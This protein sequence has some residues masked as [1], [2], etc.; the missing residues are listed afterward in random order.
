MVPVSLRQEKKKIAVFGLQPKILRAFWICQHLN[1]CKTHL[2]SAS[3]IML[4]AMHTIVLQIYIQFQQSLLRIKYRSGKVLAWLL[5]LLNWVPGF[6]S[7][8]SHIY[9][10]AAQSDHRNSQSVQGA[11][12]VLRGCQHTS[13]SIICIAKSKL[14]SCNGSQSRKQ[15]VRSNTLGSKYRIAYSAKWT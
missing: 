3:L 6:H 7:S 4:S 5:Y 9:Q 12:V 1:V 2:L 13:R 14:S 15:Q 10:A 8:I 11:A